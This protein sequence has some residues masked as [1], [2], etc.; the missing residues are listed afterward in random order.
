MTSSSGS[1]SAIG[2]TSA[3]VRCGSAAPSGTCTIVRQRPARATRRP[4]ARAGAR[5]ARR[6]RRGRCRR[7]PR[8]SR[9]STAMPMTPPS[10]RRRYISVRAGSRAAGAA[11]PRGRRGVHDLGDSSASPAARP[12]LAADSPSARR[13]SARR[14]AS[15]A[16]S[17]PASRARMPREHAEPDDRID[18]VRAR[19]ATPSATVSSAP[20]VSARSIA[21]TSFTGTP[22][23]AALGEPCLEVGERLAPRRARRRGAPSTR[24]R[25]S[26]AAGPVSSAPA[27]ERVLAPRLGPAPRGL[28]SPVRRAASRA[29]P[30]ASSARARTPRADARAGAPRSRRRRARSPAARRAARA[31]GRR[32]RSRTSAAR[33]ARRRSSRASTGARRHRALAR[34]RGSIR[35]AIASAAWRCRSSCAATA[36][37]S[38]RYD[39]APRYAMPPPARAGR[40][41]Q[42]VDPRAAGSHQPASIARCGASLA[43]VWSARWRSR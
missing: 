17:S 12:R 26:S 18:L 42:H 3:R 38:S 13:A 35:S 10:A 6:R 24:A 11:A 37:R 30:A 27:S 40:D 39:T 9:A 28:G 14:T 29:G 25:P 23:N 31:A 15:A 8:A 33:A 22:S 19:R 21:T 1:G 5:A 4:A 20:A 43:I 2:L 34:S 16:G 36:P 41:R 32:H 7:R